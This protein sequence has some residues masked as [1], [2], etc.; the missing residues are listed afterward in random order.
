MFY[1][2]NMFR[3][4]KV[5]FFISTIFLVL[6]FSFI[7]INSFLVFIYVHSKV[8]DKPF[9]NE[10]A[11]Q[12][13]NL[14]GPD[15]VADLETKLYV[16]MDNVKQI[17]YS[18][19]ETVAYENIE[20][21][22]EYQKNNSNASENQNFLNNIKPI[23]LSPILEGEGIWSDKDLPKDFDG[24]SIFYKTEY[25]PDPK[26]AYVC[27]TLCAIDMSKVDLNWVPGSSYVGI[28]GQKGEGIIPDDYLDPLVA[29][30]NGGFLPLHNGGG[31]IYDGKVFLPMKEGLGTVISD[32]HGETFISKWTKDLESQISQYRSCRQNLQ[33]LIEDG[34]VNQTSKYWG[35]VKPNEDPVYNWRSGIGISKDRRWLVFVG[36]DSLSAYTL[37]FS[38]K[39]A[40]CWNAIH[41]DMNISNIAFNFFRNI[42]GKLVPY[43]LSEKFWPQMVNK[44]LDGYTHDYFYLTIKE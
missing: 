39:M 11:D 2:N 36:G 20:Q 7:T 38:L 8:E 43:S 31:M 13:R 42:D 26:R 41:L 34:V 4:P 16:V 12:L 33:M 18:D 44:Y 25:R 3:N 27:V 32:I 15:F 40:G 10:G 17:F 21:L 5:V 23:I 19:P 22:E 28:N 30:F 24:S 9:F 14:L 35:I 29:V 6:I 1:G 37:G